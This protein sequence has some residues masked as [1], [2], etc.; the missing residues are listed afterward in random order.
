MTPD[1]IA[2]PDFDYEA[3][4]DDELRVIATLQN[5]GDSEQTVALTVR[6]EADGEP[7]EQ[8]TD[9]SVG[10][11]ESTETETVFDVTEEEFDGTIDFDWEAE[12]A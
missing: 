4:E 10:A 5:D 3:T 6:I 11:D 9:A 8:S 2:I 7:Y 12:S 1:Q